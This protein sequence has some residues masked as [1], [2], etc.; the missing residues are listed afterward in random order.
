MRH[1][2]ILLVVT[3]LSAVT[4][5]APHWRHRQ[6]GQDPREAK[7]GPSLGTTTVTLSSPQKSTPFCGEYT[8]DMLTFNK[9]VVGS[10]PAALT[11]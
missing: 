9:E 8:R 4:T 6:R 11:R 10:I 5:E 1:W 7:T 2:R 3:A